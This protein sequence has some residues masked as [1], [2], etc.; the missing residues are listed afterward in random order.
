[1]INNNPTIDKRTSGNNV[2]YGVDHSGQKKKR[3]K[4]M[5]TTH[6]CTVRARKQWRSASRVVQI[7]FACKTCTFIQTHRDYVFKSELPR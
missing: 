6:L 2:I 7:I 1:M 4:S 5:Q 3:Q